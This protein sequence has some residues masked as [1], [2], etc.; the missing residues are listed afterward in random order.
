MK[1]A[2]IQTIPEDQ[3][4]SQV[5]VGIASLQAYALHNEEGIDIDLFLNDANF[6]SQFRPVDYDLIG[7]SS[8]TF[9][10][11]DSIQLAKT[12]KGEDPSIRVII[13]GSHISGFPKSILNEY[14]DVGVVG[15]GEETFVELIRLY[16]R[17]G[18]YVA[19]DLNN[20]KG[21]CFAKDRHVVFTGYRD[22]IQ[23]I[24]T[25]PHF[26]TDF[27]KRYNALAFTATS[28]GCPY[29][30]KYC[31]SSTIW[32]E[33][34]RF[35]SPEYVIED[36]MRLMKLYPD[37]RRLLFKDDTF[38]ANK[39]ALRAIRDRYE[40]ITAEKKLMIIGSSH[41]NFIN[42]ETGILLKDIGVRKLN[43]GIES[44]S[45]R[46]MRIVKRN[47]TNL[48]RTQA[49]L[50]ICHDNGIIAG[51]SFLIGVPEETEDDLRRSYEFIIESMINNRLFTTGTLVLTPLPR[52]DSDY[53]QLA[54]KKYNIDHET[55]DWSRLDIRSWHYYRFENKKEC[56]INEWWQ[57]RKENNLLY[58]GGIP[59]E[60]WLKI[61]EPYEIELMKMNQ[62]NIEIDRSMY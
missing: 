14:L 52:E 61:I 49:T 15:E 34:L 29:D 58:I 23:D 38:T 11:Q 57:W 53:W 30:C 46:L 59:E 45:D 62:R 19:D 55:F 1:I 41:V 50:D 8:V 5:G 33:K 21:I 44:G 17:S 4:R 9:T 13:G 27:L 20:I 22:Y 7:I 28:R 39:K 32:Q 51:S 12:I 47:N 40:E 37:D 26:D 24:D 54:V 48:N 43:F 3:T 6:Y 42:P 56:S 31:N 18:R 25:I 36:I 35:H 2:L 16:K 10:F 60:K